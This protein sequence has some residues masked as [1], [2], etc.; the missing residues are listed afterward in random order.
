MT[1]VIQN[2]LIVLFIHKYDRYDINTKNVEGRIHVTYIK[3]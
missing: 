1:N 3:C 2:P